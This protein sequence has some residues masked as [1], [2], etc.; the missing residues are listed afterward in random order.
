MLVGRVGDTPMP[1]CG[2]YAGEHGAVAVTGLG[3]EIIRKMTARH[4]Y[5]LLAAGEGT[6]TACLSG[7]GLFP[8][9]LRTGVI[10]V[11]KDGYSALSNKGMAWYAS[12]S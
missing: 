12:I 6:E 10:A 2:F 8:A 3:E 4:V 9:S 7:L 11:S 1:G 5:D